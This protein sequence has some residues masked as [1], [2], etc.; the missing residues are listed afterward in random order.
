MRGT[1]CLNCKLWSTIATSAI[2]TTLLLPLLP[3]PVPSWAAELSEIQARG[4]LIVAVKDNTPPL[5]FRDES[6]ELQGFE[7]EVARSLAAEL[8]GDPNAIAWVPVRND[9]RLTVLLKGEVDL[10]IAQLSATP[11]RSRLVNFSR[12][13][14]LESTGFVTRSPQVQDL[15]D[16]TTQRI[17]VLDG[18]STIAVLRH[19]LPNARLVGV[20]SYQAA[21]AALEAGQAD[22]FAGDR[23]ILVG[24]V[25]ADPDYQLLDMRLSGDAIAIALPK[26][27]Q[28]GDLFVAINQHLRTLE[29][30]GWLAERQAFWGL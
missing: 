19:H 12:P 26:G 1:R 8:L 2:A 29:T 3:P 25:Q 14:Y 7:I 28:H 5:G 10:V 30:S 15:G 18:A 17:A 24:W 20:E 27:V 9:E 11:M 6:G 23:A 13:Y 4:Q 16:L 22:V 21:Y